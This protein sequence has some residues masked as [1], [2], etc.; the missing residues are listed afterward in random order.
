MHLIARICFRNNTQQITLL[1]CVGYIQ[2]EMYR[3][4]NLYSRWILFSLSSHNSVVEIAGKPLILVDICVQ[5][6]FIPIVHH[7]GCILTKNVEFPCVVCYTT[8]NFEIF[9]SAHDTFI[10][11]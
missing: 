6:H 11:I 4:G 8:L 9:S 2:D 3:L 10:V 5:L 7:R 1:L